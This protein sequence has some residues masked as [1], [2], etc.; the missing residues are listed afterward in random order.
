MLHVYRLYRVSPC[1]TARENKAQLLMAPHLH[2]TGPEFPTC[3]FKGL[4]SEP[5]MPD[6]L[7]DA[8]IIT[9]CTLA[10]LPHQYQTI[11][12]HMSISNRMACF[13]Q[14]IQPGGPRMSSPLKAPFRMG[15][16]FTHCSAL[17]KLMKY[18]S[19]KEH[20]GT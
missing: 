8:G 20:D 14:A 1:L 13:K 19:K 15:E 10:V 3:Q 5:P 11:S 17:G 6:D 9:G 12:C 4:Q 2:A 18:Q 7:S 16:V